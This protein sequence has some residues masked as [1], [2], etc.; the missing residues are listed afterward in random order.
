MEILG[1]RP[2]WSMNGSEMLS[3]LDAAFA[4]IA[5]LETFA[6]HLMAGLET[7]GY[8]QEL[9]AGT[10][11]RLL[12]FRY[13]IDAT[14]ARRDVHLAKSLPKYPAVAAA[15]P[16]PDPHAAADTGEDGI[17]EDGAG[18]GVLLHPA[19]A[20]AIV[21]AL[22]KVPADGPGRRSAGRRAGDGGIGPHPRSAGPA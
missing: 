14:K 10:T 5:R 1:E 3:S 20:E 13:R 15:L 8:A 22:D 18:G 11:A 7:T 4:E 17:A 9:G 19:Q 21:A 6:L 2:V 12:T 16:N